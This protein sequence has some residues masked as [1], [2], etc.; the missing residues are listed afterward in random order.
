MCN[1]STQ[2]CILVYE[3]YNCQRGRQKLQDLYIVKNKR[4]DRLNPYG[5]SWIKLSYKISKISTGFEVLF[6]PH[7]SVN[8]PQLLLRSQ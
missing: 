7:R 3:K 4:N 6:S 8:V 5:H 1:M 2:K